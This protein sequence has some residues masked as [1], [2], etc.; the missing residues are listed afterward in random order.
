MRRTV[1]SRFE[2]EQLESCEKLM[3]LI[4]NQNKNILGNVLGAFVVNGGS[5]LISVA[6]LPLYLRFFR[7]KRCW[8]LVYD[9]VRSELG[10]PI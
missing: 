7:I 1:R 5:L 9:S 10:D 6:L 3:K 4:S 2:T 8:G